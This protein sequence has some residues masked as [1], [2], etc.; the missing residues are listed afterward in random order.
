MG[1]SEL[2]GSIY[3]EVL[4]EERQVLACRGWAGENVVRSR[5]PIG[6]PREGKP[7]AKLARSIYRAVLAWVKGASWRTLGGRVRKGAQWEINQASSR[8][9]MTGPCTPRKSHSPH[10]PCI[11]E[12]RSAKTVRGRSRGRR[13]V[14]TVKRVLIPPP[15]SVMVLESANPYKSSERESR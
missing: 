12:Q 3:R 1:R 13:R 5:R 4:A 6:R 14:Q 9:S 15:L 10:H 7:Q 11:N 2:G 8:K